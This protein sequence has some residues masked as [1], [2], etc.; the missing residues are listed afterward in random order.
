MPGRQGGGLDPGAGGRVQA[1]EGPGDVDPRARLVAG[2][3]LVH[4]V[5]VAPFPAGGEARAQPGEL[6]RRGRDGQPAALH[7]V[8][9]DRL[10]RADPA[11][12]VDGGPELGLE[13]PHAG[14][15]PAARA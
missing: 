7:E 6:R 4:V 5:A 10:G 2:Q 14:R 9:V 12:L 8:A 3:E 15:P 1:A 13:R 11:H